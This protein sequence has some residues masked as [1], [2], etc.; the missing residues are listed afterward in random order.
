[1]RLWDL[2]KLNLVMV[3]VFRLESILNTALAASK[4]R[5]LASKVI[6]SDSKITILLLLLM[7]SR[8]LCSKLVL[9]AEN[10][11][12]Q[13]ATKFSEIFSISYVFF[14]QFP[15]SL[16]ILCRGHHNNN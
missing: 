10:K 12:E 11:F 16:R 5:F 2:D 6:K 13:A 7:F 3:V 4:K 9:D 1:V 8:N 14:S 15:L